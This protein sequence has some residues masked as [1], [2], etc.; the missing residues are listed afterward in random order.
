M[1][2]MILVACATI[3][4][5]AAVPDGKVTSKQGSVE[6]RT[7][8]GKI[9]CNAPFGE[10]MRLLDQKDDLALVQALCA[11]GWVE[12]SKIQRVVAARKSSMTFN[13]FDIN[14]YT[15]LLRLQNTFNDNL[16]DPP[17][18]VLDRNFRDFLTNTVDREKQERAHGEN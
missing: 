6:L 14:A 5:I 17:E 12:S 15:D 13:D 7:T 16:T 2:A 8:D 3:A 18:V 1:K 4:A 9:L 10:E 11:K